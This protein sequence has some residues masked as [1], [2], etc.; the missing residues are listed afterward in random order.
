MKIRSAPNIRAGGGHQAD[1]AGAVDRHATALAD[2]GIAHRLVAGGEDV[3]EEQHAFV[4]HYVG[5]HERPAVG[6]GHP[7][8]F[9]LATGTPPYRWL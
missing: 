4:F 8:V 5:N 2:A 7:N 1:R 6:L 9:G 3:A